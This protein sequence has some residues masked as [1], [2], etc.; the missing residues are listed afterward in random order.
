MRPLYLCGSQLQ[1]ALRL[2]Y[3]LTFVNLVFNFNHINPQLNLLLLAAIA[4][5]YKV[6]LKH[7]YTTIQSIYPP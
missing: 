1:A 6:S 7:Q 2:R 4:L 5:N 3:S